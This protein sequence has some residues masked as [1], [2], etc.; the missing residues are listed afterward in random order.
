MLVNLNKVLPRARAHKYAVGAFNINNLEIAQGVVAAAAKLGAPVIIQTSEGALEYAGMEYLAAIVHIAAETH[1]KLP[2]VFHLDH[3][4]EESLVER[5]IKSGWYTSVMI[6]A[7]RYD[8]KKN[9]KVTRRIVELAHARGMSVE[10]ELGPIMGQE[11]L[12]NVSQKEAAFTDSE[13]VKRFVAETK[14][15]ALAVSIG[16]AHGAVKYVA[17]EQPVLDLKRLK[18]I[19]AITKIS[20]VLHGASSVPHALITELHQSCSRMGDC[21]RVHDA[22]G[23]PEAQIKKAIAL[24]ISK[25]NVDTDIRIAFTSAVREKLLTDSS[26]ID[27]RKLLGPARDAV[28]QL[29]EKKIKLF[30]FR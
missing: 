16:T 20:L 17:G 4:K 11:D 5:T 29:I 6:D 28:Q 30:G 8:F 24:G 12:V 3:G 7:S 14:C 23:V 13:E 21:G 27:P 26:F 9:I 18:E 2:I 19:A 10:A 15:D 22:I 1:K 25:V